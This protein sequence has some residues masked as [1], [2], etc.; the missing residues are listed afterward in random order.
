M[1]VALEPGRHRNLLFFLGKK[2]THWGVRRVA[3]FKLKWMMF[4]VG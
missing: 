1:K 4:Q 2:F 3:E